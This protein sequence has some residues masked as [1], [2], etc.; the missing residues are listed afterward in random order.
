M[1]RLDQM[2]EF[3]RHDMFHKRNVLCREQPVEM[4]PAGRGAASPAVAE[5]PYLK[6][7]R[8]DAKKFRVV[9]QKFREFCFELFSKRG[10]DQP[11]SGFDWRAGGQF[12]QKLSGSH[13]Q[14]GPQGGFY[15]TKLMLATEDPDADAGLQICR[16]DRLVFAGQILLL[17]DPRGLLLHMR[18]DCGELHSRR[19]GDFHQWTAD[20]DGDGF[21]FL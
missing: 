7:W 6:W 16:I 12:Q 18:A 11:L 14:S 20:G 3:M 1:P 17:D 2:T 8:L 21:S 15:N 10:L 4:D 19:R 5:F 9:I 13:F